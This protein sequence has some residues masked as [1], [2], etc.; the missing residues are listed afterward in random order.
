MIKTFL[1]NNGNYIFLL[2]FFSIK[3]PI[4]CTFLFLFDFIK[5]QCNLR[6][7]RNRPNGAEPFV[8][9]ILASPF[10]SGNVEVSGWAKFFNYQLNNFP[11]LTETANSVQVFLR[12]ERRYFDYFIKAIKICANPN[13]VYLHSSLFHLF[14]LGYCQVLTIWLPVCNEKNRLPGINTATFKNKTKASWSL[15]IALIMF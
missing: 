15:T 4:N 9:G 11:E 12:R 13:H 2:L 3:L 1:R 6:K 8:R 5:K 14:C 7:K 10:T